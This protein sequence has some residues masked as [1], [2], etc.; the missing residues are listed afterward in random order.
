[1][2]TL[3]EP[4]PLAIQPLDAA[5]L[6]QKQRAF[7]ATGKTLDV[8]WRLQQLRK[9][10]AAMHK[11]EPE[12]HAALKADLNKNEFESYATETGFSLEE[13][14]HTIA[15]LKSWARTTYLPGPFTQML[16]WG[17]L[18]HEPYGSALVIAPWN[19][20]YQLMITPVIGAISAGNCVVI[21]PSELAPHTAAAIEKMMADTFPSEF[22]AVVSGGVP[23]TTALLQQPWDYIFFTGSTQVGRIVMRAAAEHLTP[24]TLELGGK[25]PCIVDGTVNAALAARR[26]AWGKFTNAGQTCV[27]PDYLLV[28]RGHTEPLIAALKKAITDMFG[29]DPRLSPDYGRIITNL[30]FK[31]LTEQLAQGTVVHG[32]QS[33]AAERYISPTLL[34][35]PEMEAGIMQEEIFG[36][37]LP[38]LE[39]NTTEEAIAFV[40]ARPKPLAFYVFTKDKQTEQALL[41]RTSA[42]GGCV[43]DTL[44]HLAA[45]NL[46]FGGVGGSGM[47][48]YHGKY[49][50]ETFSHKKGILKKSTLLD[51]P[52]R[53]APFK[54][55]IGL[56][57]KLLH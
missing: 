24:V 49:S 15:N 28:K 43:N 53:Y 6:L 18:C 12:L 34:V 40:N 8:N 1:M 23:E 21:K 31:R 32:G 48:A 42:G 27:A 14:G 55:K 3:A 29:A 54:G 25:S 44:V 5:A 38:I 30:H 52:I 56:L 16:S 10:K 2:Q 22:V 4:K 20:P 9:L 45:A 50:F 47:G 51:I 57:K 33:N 39:Y 26:I 37:I 36:P 35:H 17:K 7:F 46:P 11:W 13:L 41:S 19:Y